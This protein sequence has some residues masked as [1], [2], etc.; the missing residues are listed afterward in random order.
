M[1]KLITLY[2]NVPL[3]LC[4]RV[5]IYFNSTISSGFKHSTGEIFNGNNFTL[6]TLNE[7]CYVKE[8][9]KLRNTK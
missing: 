5:Y 1:F 7:E 2:Q 9:L 8:K 6:Q 3:K 4:V